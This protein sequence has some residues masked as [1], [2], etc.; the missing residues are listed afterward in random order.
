MG[1]KHK[2]LRHWLNRGALTVLILVFC[3]SVSVAQNIGK[4]GG[5][6]S[7]TDERRELRIGDRTLG[8]ISTSGGSIRYGLNVNATKTLT[9]RMDKV[10]DSA[11]DPKLT[12]YDSNGSQVATDDDGGEGLNALISVT[13]QPGQYVVA[14]QAVG[15]SSGDFL[16]RVEEQQA[17]TLSLG[18][19]VLGE[20]TTS[21]NEVAYRVNIP[22]TTNLR[23]R[24]NKLLGSTLDPKVTLVDGSGTEIATDDDGGGS[25]NALLQRS[26][27]SGEY[28]VRARRVGTSTGKFMLSVYDQD[29]PPGG[30]SVRVGDSVTEIINDP[31]VPAVFR[32][33]VND[34]FQ[35]CRITVDKT[36]GSN[37]DPN[38]IVTNRSGEIIGSDDDSG[39][40]NGALLRLSLGRGDYQLFV[41]GYGTTTGAFRLTVAPDRVPSI[42]V[43]ETKR[44]VLATGGSDLYRFTTPR[45][46][47]VTISLRKAAAPATSQSVQQFRQ[48]GSIPS[49]G[50][51]SRF[52]YTVDSEQPLVVRVDKIGD[53]SLDPKVTVYDQNGN[54][55]GSDDD[56]G[57]GL[58]ARL[59]RVFAPGVYTIQVSSVNNSSGD[60]ILMVGPDTGGGSTLDPKL[61]VKNASGS[62]VASDDDGGEGND[63]LLTT[64]LAA[65]TYQ[66]IAMAY[67][68]TSGAYELTVSEVVPQ[69]MGA[70][71]P[72]QTKTGALTS[73]GRHRYSLRVASS[74]VIAIDVMKAADSSLDPQ[75]VL[76]GSSGEE[77]AMNDDGG[78]GNNARIIRRLEPGSYEIVVR[79]YQATAGGYTLMVESFADTRTPAPQREQMEDSPSKGGREG[80]GSEPE[81]FGKGAG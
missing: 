36:E 10:L 17:T 7:A 80:S 67:G 60:F 61:I 71:S 30:A 40:G 62:E 45:A 76:R 48:I 4:D 42:S 37:L 66:I 41:G 21:M 3:V 31:N 2:D 58:N 64:N 51:F 24:M 52:A 9:I 29:A 27:P 12:I 43:G 75:V 44:G 32:L 38:L 78:D 73:G 1:K 28:V 55:V 5:S 68:S 23:I 79:G 11:I 70:I 39:E 15:T 19:A 34:E 35:D 54:E 25:L 13:L 18:T 16:L 81:G 6:G 22:R 72:G 69:D 14:A 59:S 77:I 56:S 63:A 33:T 46:R 49:G 47:E 20:I 74:A 65:G 53:G 26:V 50:G 8:T 57:D